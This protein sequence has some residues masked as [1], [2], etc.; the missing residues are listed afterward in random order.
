[1]DSIGSRGFTPLTPQVRPNQL[2][3]KYGDGVDSLLEVALLPEVDSLVSNCMTLGAMAPPFSQYRAE[4]TQPGGRTSEIIQAQRS[5]GETRSE[6]EGLSVRVDSQST[7]E[8]G[9]T[10]KRGQVEDFRFETRA[11]FDQESGVYFNEG[12]IVSGVSGEQIEFRR[13][14]RQL[15]D[16]SGTEFSGHIGGLAEHGTIKMGAGGLS[17]ERQIGEYQISGQVTAQPTRPILP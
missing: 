5:Q 15:P 4:I 2:S 8:D 12:F 1:M 9:V 10:V 11:G 17:I 7:F 16:R 13:E 14:M 6:V 3:L